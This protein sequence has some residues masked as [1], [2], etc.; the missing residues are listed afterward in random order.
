M[1]AHHRLKQRLAA[2]TCYL[3]Q[4]SQMDTVGLIDEIVNGPGRILWNRNRVPYPLCAHHQS[5][6]EQRRDE[7]QDRLWA[8]GYSVTFSDPS[9]GIP[10]SV[11]QLTGAVK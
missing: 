4:C 5:E 1:S 11:H 10:G 7:R 8:A 2:V 9:A 6:K 3:C